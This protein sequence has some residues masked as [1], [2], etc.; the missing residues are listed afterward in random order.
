MNEREARNQLA[1]LV[2]RLDRAYAPV[3]GR[4]VGGPVF[5]VAL[6]LG[7]MGCDC[8]ERPAD[9]EAPA[10]GVEPVPISAT[11]YGVEMPEPPPTVGTAEPAYM[12]PVPLVSGDAAAP[13]AP[14]SSAQTR[15]APKSVPPFR[16]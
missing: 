5:A 16:P 14:S 9:T 12:A 10:Y 4:Q 13:P 3:V 2:A 6:G 15:P 1:Q 7:A 11:A 8:A